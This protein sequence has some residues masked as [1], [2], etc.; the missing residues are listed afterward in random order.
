MT[1][2]RRSLLKRAAA[3]P[4][5]TIPLSS[6]QVKS[7][8]STTPRTLADRFS[9]W[10]NVKDF[11]A[12][13][14]GVAND[15]AAIQAALDSGA[16]HPVVVY[17]P[18]GTY[19]VW[20]KPGGFHALYINYNNITMLGDGRD[21]SII[22]FYVAGGLNPVTNWEVIGGDVWRG[23]AIAV[24]WDPTVPQNGPSG[25]FTT[26]A[27]FTINGL[28]ITGNA[29]ADTVNF[30]LGGGLP[31]FPADSLT[32]L[33]WDLTHHVVWLCTGAPHGPLNF[34]NSEFDSTHGENI[35]VQGGGV[36]DWL[37]E[38]C[39]IHD[40]NADNISVSAQLVVRGCEI[41]LGLNAAVEN[42]PYQ[43]DNT[44]ENCD[45]HDCNVGICFT[46]QADFGPTSVSGICTSRGNLIRDCAQS[47]H[48][49][50]NYIR[51][52]YIQN[53]C[54][55][56]CGDGGDAW[57]M[58]ALVSLATGTSGTR[59][60]IYIEN[61]VAV[62]DKKS[63]KNVV[64]LGVDRMTGVYFKNN[65]Y[66]KTANAVANSFGVGQ[67]I[68]I[69]GNT[70]GYIV[71]EGNNLAECTGTIDPSSLFAQAGAITL[72]INN[73]WNTA[74]YGP[75]QIAGPNPYAIFLGYNDP[76]QTQWVTVASP[77]DSH[78]YFLVS[79]GD[80]TY[81]AALL[82]DP[83]SLSPML[84]FADGADPPDVGLART[85]AGLAQINNGTYNTL[86]GLQGQYFQTGY[87]TFA[88]LPASPGVG[89][90]IGVSNSNTAVWGASIT[91]T[92]AN[93]VL[94]WWNGSHWTVIG[95]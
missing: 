6:G 45:I 55:I 9:D 54:I 86:A 42:G 53:N 20:P 56:D 73:R 77:Y 8:A 66:T 72:F 52:V 93:Q 29:P 22:S 7:T 44:F 47:A 89:T 3:I 84:L 28:R 50:Q 61:N 34:L 91:G 4:L 2:N 74:V 33:G 16:G 46:N 59:A 92:G 26:V 31:F 67:G 49:L 24:G 19:K 63:V 88:S 13:G 65:H 64:N 62:S 79:P 85:G 1:V 60:G 30:P 71:V 5:D 58:I 94:A 10:H 37:I 57:A 75:A 38:N 17:F 81:R 14:D 40:T 41:Y 90:I 69:H 11:G 78:G 23:A 32:G 83:A 68:A 21:T 18:K 95:K 15:T 87:V 76:Q 70:D 25:I 48:F 27:N 43:Q 35:I 82:L 36:V 39:I 80:A 51:Q 12:I